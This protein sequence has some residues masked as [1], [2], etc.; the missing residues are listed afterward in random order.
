MKRN[1][2]RMPWAA[3]W[4]G[5]GG[6]GLV[7]L[8]PLD[9]EQPKPAVAAPPAAGVAP[10]G[11]TAAAPREEIRPAFAYDPTGGPDGKGCFAIK[12]DRREGLAGCWKKACP[13]TGGKYYRFGARYQAQG[14]AVPR[15]SIV[16][17]L[18]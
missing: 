13:I 14:V 16:V 12:A 18:H 10:D 2:W 15:R 5:V 4:L 9:A 3:A 1:G 17:E 6:L 7:A 11:W 8:S